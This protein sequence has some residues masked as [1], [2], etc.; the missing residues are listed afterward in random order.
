MQRAVFFFKIIIN[1]NHC[2]SWIKKTANTP[3]G[4]LAVKKK[5]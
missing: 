3:C 4:A 2:N 5:L 1:L